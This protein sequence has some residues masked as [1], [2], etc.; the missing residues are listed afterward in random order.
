[1]SVDMSLTVSH[2]GVTENNKQLAVGD[3]VEY[4]GHLPWGNVS[5]ALTDG[6]K[7]VANQ[8]CFKEF[9]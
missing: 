5:I 6:S 7:D 3:K 8:A 1:M 4:L 9:R 2:K